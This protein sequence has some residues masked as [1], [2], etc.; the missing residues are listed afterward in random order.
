M[1]VV[2]KAPKKA[3]SDKKDVLTELLARREANIKQ[4]IEWPLWEIEEEL[5]RAKVAKEGFLMK[6]PMHDLSIIEEHI[7]QLEESY[8]VRSTLDAES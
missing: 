6:N 4:A 3:E 7:S 1:T 2:N 5:E 8:K